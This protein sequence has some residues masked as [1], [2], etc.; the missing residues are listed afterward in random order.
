MCRTG[1]TA[2][3][4]APP[5]L[6]CVLA[7]A[8][9]ARSLE[10]GF[11]GGGP[12]SISA[13]TDAGGTPAGGGVP[14]VVGGSGAAPGSSGTPRTVCPPGA[15]VPSGGAAVSTP[16]PSVPTRTPF[17]CAP[18]PEAFIFPPPA[19]NVPGFYSRCASF[20]VGQATAVAMSPDGRLAALAT[21]DGILRVVEVASRQVVAVLPSP[22]ATIDYAAFAPDGQSILTLARAQREVTLWRSA[23]WT[24][25]T[26]VWTTILPGHRY[27]SMF[28]GG[29]AFTPDARSAVVSPGTGVF[30]LDAA[31]GAVRASNNLGAAILDVAYGL[32][33]SRIVVAVASLLAHCNHNPNG[34]TVGLFDGNL[35]LVAT[36]ADL[37]S[38]PGARGIPAFRVSPTA[39]LVLVA[40]GDGDPPGLHA[41]R[42]SDGAA[43]PAPGL[44]TLPLTFTPDGKSMLVD[45]GDVLQR[46]RADDQSLESFV[47]IGGAAGPVAVSADGSVVAFG[48]AGDELLRIWR[49][50]EGA[51]TPVCA[52]ERPAIPG[53]SS[54]SADGQLLAIPLQDSIRVLRRSDG[55]PVMWLPISGTQY[56]RVDLSARGNYLAIGP[57]GAATGGSVVVR[58]PSGAPVADF[59]PDSSR[60]LD[61]LFTPNEDKVYSAGKR[62]TD[63]TVDAVTLTSPR[64]V[65]SRIV[66]SFTTL[67]GF[68]DGCP[69]LYAAARGAWRSCGGC[70]DAPIAGSPSDQNAFGGRGAVLSSDGMFV[71]VAGPTRESGVTLWRLRPDPAPLLTIGPRADE[72]WQPREYPVA[73]T[74]GAGRILTGAGYDGACFGGPGYEVYVRDAAAGAVLDTLPPGIMAVDAAVRTIAYGPQLWC[75]R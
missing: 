5:V 69:V 68:S 17:S 52:A 39:D 44:D 47:T 36:L 31:T 63:Y 45:A 57:A 53:L 24:P 51:V 65:T 48:G 67:L 29:L 30:V 28:G 74:R 58:L 56:T 15:E 54:L 61:F 22:R 71:A 46:V 38:Y 2:R 10:S 32:D 60:W 1:G 11:D 12:G 49:T 18:L 70:D 43:A 8:C 75:A 62:S 14:G 25:A 40:R 26:P 34:G 72:S 35:Q 9:G 42:L 27:D 64:Q 21:G 50:D 3:G 59:A 20:S 23:D 6:A 41:F 37:G 55:V 19:S 13:A 33:G 66:P 7:G 4:W 73:L 16:P